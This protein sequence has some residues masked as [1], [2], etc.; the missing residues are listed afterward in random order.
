MEKDKQLKIYSIKTWK[1]TFSCIESGNEFFRCEQEARDEE[2]RK[3][4]IISG[5]THLP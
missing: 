1:D 4:K 3:R 2:L 5:M